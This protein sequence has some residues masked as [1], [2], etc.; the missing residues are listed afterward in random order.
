MEGLLNET[1]KGVFF[2]FSILF[3][4]SGQGVLIHTILEFS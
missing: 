2:F 4:F 3:P 1:R